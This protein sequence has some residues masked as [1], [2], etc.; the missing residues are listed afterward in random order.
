MQRVAGCR[1]IALPPSRL[2]DSRIVD[3]SKIERL[4]TFDTRS[5]NPTV[6]FPSVVATPG[7]G[8]IDTKLRTELGDVVLAR[9]QERG[10]HEQ[11]GVPEAVVCHANRSFERHD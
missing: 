6:V 3:P 8:V 5:A 1:A 10:E 4:P 11:L 2:I 7:T 9:V